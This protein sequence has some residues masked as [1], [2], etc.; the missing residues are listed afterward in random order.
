MTNPPFHVG[1]AID[2]GV[3]QALIDR[4]PSALRSKGQ[5]VLVANRFIPYDK[6]M[7]DRFKT[8]VSLAETRQYH[9]LAASDLIRSHNPEFV[10]RSLRNY[11]LYF[12][13]LRK[14]SGPL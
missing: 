11:S 2:Y 9:V 1:K 3:T 5:L 8:V 13:A 10:D 4:A 7:W 12:G 6:L 14:T